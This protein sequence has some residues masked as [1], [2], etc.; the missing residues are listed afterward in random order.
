LAKNQREVLRPASILPRV[1]RSV[2]RGVEEDLVE[3]RKAMAVAAAGAMLSASGV[4]AAGVGLRH[5]SELAAI[6][7]PSTTVSTAPRP[8]AASTPEPVFVTEIRDVYDRVVIPTSSPTNVPA[9][10]AADDVPPPAAATQPAAGAPGT[11]TTGPST[12]TTIDPR[13]E[14][15][16]IPEDW[17]ADRPI[18]PMPEDCDEPHL[19]DNGV[20]NCG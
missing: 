18:P 13:Y 3:R 7:P 5:G 9:S 19:E 16:E 1:S 2:W 17:P 12:T 4:V 20:W 8:E 11:T 10:A 6:E 15:A 14:D